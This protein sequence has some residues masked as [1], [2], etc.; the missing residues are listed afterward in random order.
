MNA[1]GSLGF[2]PPTHT[3]IDWDRFGAFVTNP[4]SLG[5]RQPAANARQVSYAGGFVLH[6][7]YPNPGLETALRRFRL[8]WSHAPL[9]V[10]VHLIPRNAHELAT[11][12]PLL[13][14]C[15]NL[16]GLE[17]GIAPDTTIEAGVELLQ[18][19]FSE[20]PVILRLPL[21]RAREL[22][23]YLEPYLDDG[24][25]AAISLGPARG[26]LPLPEGGFFHGRLYGPTILPVALAAVSA[27]SQGSLPVIGAGGIYR[28]QDINA[29]LSAGATAVQLDTVLWRGGIE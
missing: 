8:A 25:V 5:R 17:V 13:E 18:A 4:I 12:I 6:T 15:D 7:G 10:V 3:L 22:I 14:Y 2:V 24:R 20:L 29:M 19:T 1:A 16:V 27:L 11:M 26:E 9:P 21:D 23:Q 28:R